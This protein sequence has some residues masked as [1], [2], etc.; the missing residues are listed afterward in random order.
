MTKLMVKWVH[1]QVLETV[2]LFKETPFGN[3]ITSCISSKIGT[4]VK[5]KNCSLR[6]QVLFSSRR[7]H[8]ETGGK[9]FQSYLPWKCI[10][11]ASRGQNCVK[12]RHHITISDEVL[13]DPIYYKRKPK[14]KKKENK[15]WQAGA[16]TKAC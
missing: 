11:S 5:E 12:H 1:L 8:S 15:K 13:C 14:E 7:I 16:L 6:E 9:F 4:T 10:H 2:F 3:R